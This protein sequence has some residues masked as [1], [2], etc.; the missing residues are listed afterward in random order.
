MVHMTHVP[1]GRAARESNRGRIAAV[2]PCAEPPIERK[3][4]TLTRTWE[5]VV[6]ETLRQRRATIDVTVGGADMADL[7]SDCDAIELAA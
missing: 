3:G 6:Q 5:V 7:G 1:G 4:S 2:K